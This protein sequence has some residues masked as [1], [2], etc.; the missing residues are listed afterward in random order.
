MPVHG[1][2]PHRLLVR[3][4][5]HSTASFHSGTAVEDFPGTF[6]QV[7]AA[8]R[9]VA[10]ALGPSNPFVFDAMLLTSELATNA[11]RHTRSARAGFTVSIASG[12][13]WAHVSVH[14]GGAPGIPCACKARADAPSGRGISM[15]ELLAR[16][17]GFTRENDGATVWFELGEP[18]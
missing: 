15:V 13:C 3:S 2:P 11:V 17:W 8:R 7:R 9:F 12:S 10:R 4:T 16:R 1:G 14:D 18:P 6:V 5:P